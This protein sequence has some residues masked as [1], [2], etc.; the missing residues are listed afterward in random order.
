M[1]RAIGTNLA[2][3]HV[4]GVVEEAAIS[5]SAPVD[6]VLSRFLGGG[7]DHDRAVELLGQDRRRGLG[8]EV[9]EVDDQGVD[10]LRPELLEGQESVLLVLDDGRDAGDGQPGFPAFRGDAERALPGKLD[11]EAIAADGD[12][13]EAHLG[14][15]R[16]LSISFFCP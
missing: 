2:Q 14:D 10:L 12:E 16:H 15:V 3:A 1:T 13:A 6:E 7:G 5:V 11:G 8:A 9:A 4:V